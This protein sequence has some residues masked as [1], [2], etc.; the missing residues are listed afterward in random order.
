[1]V[2]CLRWL[3]YYG[4]NG[5]LIQMIAIFYFSASNIQF[6][7]FVPISMIRMLDEMED[8]LDTAATNVNFITKKTRALIK[9][10]GGKKTFLIIISLVLV[11]IILL[12]LIVYS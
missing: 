2:N 7:L 11:V 9:Q 4:R 3:T 8:D 1:M 10:S 12:F 5:Y 6:S